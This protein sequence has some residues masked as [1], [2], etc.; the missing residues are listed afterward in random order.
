[1][2]EIITSQNFIIYLVVINLI[3]YAI[4]FID[5]HKAKKGSWRIPEKTIF[6]VTAIGGGIGTIVGMYQFRHKTKKPLFKF[7]LPFLLILDIAVIICG[8]TM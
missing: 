1:M 6:I 4:M 5:K 8:L 7:G 2:K 3:G